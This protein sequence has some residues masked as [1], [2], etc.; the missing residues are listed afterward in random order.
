MHRFALFI[1]AI[2]GL[3]QLGAFAPTQALSSQMMHATTRLFSTE[4]AVDAAPAPTPAPATM[5]APA[6]PL[7]QEEIDAKYPEAARLV[8][9]V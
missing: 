5:V 8:S 7:T 1:V 9:R 2:V 6:T 4:A 3:P